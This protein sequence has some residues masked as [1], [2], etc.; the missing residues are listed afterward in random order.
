MAGP[1]IALT[2]NIFPTLAPAEKALAK[3][4]P[5]FRMAKSTSAEDILEVPLMT[6]PSCRFPVLK[7]SSSI[8]AKSSREGAAAVAVAMESPVC[9]APAGWNG[10]RK[11]GPKLPQSN[12]G[13][14][15][16]D[17]RRKDRAFERWFR[18]GCLTQRR[19]RG[20]VLQQRGAVSRALGPLG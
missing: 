8:L 11:H 17:G 2:E 4:N 9:G 10:V 12:G 5:T 14:G 3:L 16:P 18:S 6:V 13:P 1:V 19:E 15:I 7:D 20:F